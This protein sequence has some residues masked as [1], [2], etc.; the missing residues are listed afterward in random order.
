MKFPFTPK[1]KE[2]VNSMWK[3]RHDYMNRPFTNDKISRESGNLIIEYEDS[4][5]VG[6]Y[7]GSTEKYVRFFEGL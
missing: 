4:R 6:R 2:T 3:I 7:G 1:G 5:F